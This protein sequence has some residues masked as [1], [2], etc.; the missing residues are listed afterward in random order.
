MEKTTKLILCSTDIVVLF[1]GFA[2]RLICNKIR[3]CG[4]RLCFCL[5][6]NSAPALVG[7]LESAVL[8][9]QSLAPSKGSTNLGAFST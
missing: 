3:R 8:S 7:P 4:R 6:V 1:L 5:Q 2:H 9:D